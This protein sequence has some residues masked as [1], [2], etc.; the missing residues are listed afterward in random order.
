MTINYSRPIISFFFLLS[1]LAVVRQAGAVLGEPASSVASD[2]KA[3]SAVHRATTSRSGYTI[4][5]I[6]SAVNTIREYVSPDGIVFAV[7]WNGITSPD[8]SQLLGSYAGDYQKALKR[9]PL[10]AGK[11]SLRVNADSVVVER[12]GHMRNLQGR[13]Y[14]PALLPKGVGVDE[15]R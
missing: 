4:Q 5:E 14:V 10:V 7:A 12:W 3:L 2:R 11:R 13:A 15:I 1:F 9:T 6:V 8:L